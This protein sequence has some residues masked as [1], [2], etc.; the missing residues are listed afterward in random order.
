MV[1]SVST[2]FEKQTPVGVHYLLFYLKKEKP[3]AGI[4]APRRGPAGGILVINIHTKRKNLLVYRNN[5]L[6]KEKHAVIK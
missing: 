1:A 4:L 2:A 3:A 5:S 6:E